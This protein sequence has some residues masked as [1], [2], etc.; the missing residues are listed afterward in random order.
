MTQYPS[1]ETVKAEIEA[2]FKIKVS[3]TK[4]LMDA[5]DFN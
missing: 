2:K 5:V 4:N 1:E 3:R